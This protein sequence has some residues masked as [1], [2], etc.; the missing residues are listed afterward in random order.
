MGLLTISNGCN[1]DASEPTLAS[2][3]RTP[4]ANLTAAPTAGAALQPDDETGQ[5]RLSFRQPVPKTPMPGIIEWK[6]LAERA[7]RASKRLYETLDPKEAGLDFYHRWNELLGQN[8]NTATGSGVAMGDYDGDGLV[9]V[10]LPRTTDGGRLFRNLGGFH[11]EDVTERVGIG[12]GE[13]RWTLGATFVDIDNDGDLDLYVCGYRCP[14]HLYINGGD[15]TFTERARQFGLDFV[16]ASI[17]MSFADY[18]L[19]GD[20]DGYLVTNHLPPPKDIEYRLVYDRRGIPSVPEQ[21]REFHDT[22]QL[23]GGDYGVIEVGQ[24][25]HLYRNNGDSTFSDVSHSAGIEGNHKGLAATWWDYNDDGFSDLYVANDFYAPDRL[26]RNNQDGTFTDVAAQ[27]LP[28]TPWFSMGCDL[29][30]LNNDGLFDLIATDMSEPTTYR[31]KTSMNDIYEDGWFLERPIPRQYMRNAVYLNTG[32][33]RF[34]EIAYLTGMDSTGW[35]WSA[36]CADLD[37]D[38]L[39]DVHITNGM[40]RDWANTD[41]KREALRRGPNATTAFTAYW[42]AQPPLVQGDYA[43]RNRGDLKFDDVSKAWGLVEES[44]SFGAAFGDLDGDG[45]LDLIVNNLDAPLSIYR[46]NADSGQAIIVRLKGTASNRWGIGATVRLRAG[47]RLQAGYLTLARGFMSSSDP[48]LHFGLGDADIIDE[49]EVAWPS[50]LKQAF[51]NLPVDRFYTITEPVGWAPPTKGPSHGSMV[52]DAHPTALFAPSDAL[53]P[54]AHREQPFDD[55]AR[56]PLLSVRL[57]QL[58]PGLAAGDA[59]NDQLEDLFLGGASGNVGTLSMN[60]GKGKWSMLQDLFPPWSGDSNVEDMGVLLFDADGDSDLDLLLVSG[61]VECEPGDESLR[62]RIF[63]NDGS[64]TFAKPAAEVLPDLRDSGSVAVA[65]DYDRDG[66]LDLFIGSRSIP[67]RF[68]ETPTSRL[69]VNNGGTFRDA[70]TEHATQLQKTGL[71][72][73]ALWSDVNNDGWIDLLVTHEWGPVKLFVNRSGR[74]HDETQSA[75]LANSLGWWNGI[76]GRDLDGDQDIDYVATNIGRNTCYRPTADRPTKLFYGDFA[77]DGKPVA[78]EAKYDERGRLVPT[79]NKPEVE[80]ALPMVEAEFPTYHDFASATL[81]DIVGEERLADALE[82]TA[83]TVESVILRNDGQGR[84]AIEPLP[85]LAQTSPGFGAVMS[86]FDADGFTDVY[87]VQNS[88]SPRREIGRWD[89]GI[90][91]LLMGSKDGRLSPAPFAA[92]GLVVP[93]D[94]KSAVVTDLNGDAWPDIVVGVNNSDVMAFENQAVPGRRQAVIR[95]RGRAGNPIAVGSQVSV[96]RDDGVRQTAEVQAGGGYLSQQ[97][98]AL[99]FGLGAGAEID[100]IEVRW[101]DGKLTRHKPQPGETIIVITQPGAT[102]TR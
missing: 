39:V 4:A 29:G 42:D 3:A 64:G 26:Y 48:T 31:S 54:L 10:F 38:G 2:D 101:P 27:V 70:T 57:S 8:R 56:Q 33:E 87:L 74:L 20:L 24:Y 1:R 43:F 53:A 79:R 41:I 69:L 34:L 25:D 68:P 9:D 71:V 85:T 36:R 16:G 78:M 88:F 28:H 58:G 82:L 102:P 19:D 67:G 59:N 90:S 89:G 99:W 5:R 46:N 96:T 22:L 6:P 12:R 84:F 93:G 15:G 55:F 14:N 52:G 18:D 91:V 30:D 66:D 77:G 50:G 47:G 44:I 40:S 61:G 62:D 17:G 7:A 86:D 92:S 32:M 73:G 37:L 63:L 81:A 23:P 45:D 49:L 97:S 65:A 13:G 72:T 95:L 35:T 11:F 75:G 21:Y 100:A 80:K 60:Q 83:N 94:A 76:A 51:T 98:C